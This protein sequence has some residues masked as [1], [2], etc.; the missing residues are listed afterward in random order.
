MEERQRLELLFHV[1]LS[2]VGYWMEGGWEDKR[3]C[4]PLF[5]EAAEKGHEECLWVL[6]V[7]KGARPGTWK[8]AFCNTNV[9]LGWYI[10]GKM[11]A[12]CSPEQLNL[13]Q[14]SAEAGCSW[15]QLEYAAYFKSG[16]IVKQDRAAYLSW[17]EKAA[18]QDNPEALYR[19]G[20]WFAYQKDNKEATLQFEASAK[21]G[22]AAAMKKLA[23]RCSIGADCAVDRKQAVIWAAKGKSK[24]LDAWLEDARRDFEWGR[25]DDFDY[26]FNELCFALGWGLHVHPSKRKLPDLVTEFGARCIRYYLACIE[27]QRIAVMTF[28]LC[29][30]RT[31]GVKD[32]GQIIGR[33]VWED[34]EQCCVLKRFADEE[35]Y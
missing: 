29:W 14:K 33:M 3:G 18:E 32:V 21:L 7:I 2:K 9:P 15:G 6:E 1:A 5:T 8:K 22:W 24:M 10:G 23:Q 25:T 27:A 30:T 31:L 20:E 16:V 11:C 35:Q 4:G 13:M 28:M 19:L 26:N 12:F 34:R 17:L